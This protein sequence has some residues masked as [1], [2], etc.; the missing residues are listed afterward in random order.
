[1]STNS[2]LFDKEKALK[3]F[4]TGFNSFLDRNHIKAPDVAQEMGLKRSTVYTWKAGRGFPDFQ[5]ISKLLGMGM[6]M[7]E[8]FGDE[9]DKIE[10]ISELEIETKGITEHLLTWQ[11]ASFSASSIDMP[12]DHAKEIEN[13]LNKKI[14]DNK[15]EIERLKME[16][17]LLR[18]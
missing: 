5:T 15:K 7:R 6:T 3:D 10:K 4:S 11:M 1:M 8:M 16:L 9:L 18:K 17:E 13:S 12:E 14:G 2:F